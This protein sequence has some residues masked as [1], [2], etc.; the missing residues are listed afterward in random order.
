MPD[1]RLQPIPALTY[2]RRFSCI[3]GGVHIRGVRLRINS[4]FILRIF[5]YR[6]SRKVLFVHPRKVGSST[7]EGKKQNKEKQEDGTKEPDEGAVERK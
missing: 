7:E 6:V 5:A 3:A 4:L 2:L 1:I